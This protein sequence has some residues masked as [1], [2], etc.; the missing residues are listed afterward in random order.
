[1]ADDARKLKAVSERDDFVEA[2]HSNVPDLTFNARGNPDPRLVRLA[3]LLGK[4][5]AR[6][7]FEAQTAKQ[8]LEGS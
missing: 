3:R 5:L 8:E 4:Q 2:M 6:Q 7:N 1:M